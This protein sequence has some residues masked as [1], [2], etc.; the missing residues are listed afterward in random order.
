MDSLTTEEFIDV[1]NLEDTVP[2]HRVSSF[3]IQ[4]M[5]HYI[6]G[7]VRMQISPTIILAA[8][9]ELENG[10]PSG[11]KEDTPFTGEYLKGLFHKHIFWA[12]RDVIF[13]NI[14]NEFKNHNIYDVFSRHSSNNLLK[15]VISKREGENRLT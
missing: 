4:Q 7:K 14:K 1:I 15:N 8:I 5:R 12:N 11:T 13:T 10:V 9:N 3:L 2:K 6:S